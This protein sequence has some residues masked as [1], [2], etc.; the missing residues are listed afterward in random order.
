MGSDAAH[1]VVGPSGETHGIP[2]LFLADSSVFPTSL[3]V[4]PQLTTMALATAIAED[5]LARGL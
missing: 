5:A 3:G 4:N 1:S 2:G